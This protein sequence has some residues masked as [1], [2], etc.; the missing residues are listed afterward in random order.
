MLQRLLM[1][2]SSLL[3]VSGCFGDPEISVKLFKSETRGSP[4]RPYCDLFFRVQNDTDYRI[5][6][7]GTDLKI[8]PKFDLEKYMGIV[9]L[10]AGASREKEMYRVV[11]T[12]CEA[13]EQANVKLDMDWP[14][15]EIEGAPQGYCFKN[16]G[17]EDIR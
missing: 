17:F 12:T 11:N 4:S 14:I 16:L 9:N 6:L 1:V 10:N 8:E 2:G 13:F 7:L 3:L 5:K 15:C